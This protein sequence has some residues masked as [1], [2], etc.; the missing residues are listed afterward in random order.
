MR[1][2]TSTLALL[3]LPALIHAQKVSLIDFIPRVENV[4]GDCD[5]VYQQAITGC[6]AKDFKQKSCSVPCVNGLASMAKLVKDACSNE[7]FSDS[8]NTDSNI[9]ALFLQGRG[10]QNLC[11]NANDVLQSQSSSSAAPSTPTEYSSTAQD[12]Q[13]STTA[14]VSST[15]TASSTDVPTSLVVDTSSSPGPT[16]STSSTESAESSQST[17]SGTSSGLSSQIFEAPSMPASWTATS[18]SSQ[19]TGSSE[20]SG[21]GSPFDVAV[22]QFSS[23]AATS[24]SAVLLIVAI[25]FALFAAQW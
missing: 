16:S 23:A 4:S 22:S 8:S 6:D 25:T 1:I 14:I 20:H 15:S 5:K 19:A 12:T 10:P 17:T 21:G 3:A 13:P 9:L 18:A 24:S 7:G 11:G 2:A